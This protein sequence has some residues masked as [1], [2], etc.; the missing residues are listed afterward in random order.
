MSSTQNRTMSQAQELV[1][2][3]LNPFSGPERVKY[4]EDRL[5]GYYTP[6]IRAAFLNTDPVMDR[7]G[8]LG[9]KEHVL[10]A[11]KY[12]RLYNIVNSTMVMEPKL[13]SPDV[14]EE[15]VSQDALHAEV[16]DAL[17]Q[18]WGANTWEI[19]EKQDLIY[20][21]AQADLREELNPAGRQV[22]SQ[23]QSDPELEGQ[24]K[25]AALKE[26]FSTAAKTLVDMPHMTL[27]V[28]MSVQNERTQEVAATI[29]SAI[30]MNQF[31]LAKE[32][33][34]TESKKNKKDRKEQHPL[35]IFRVN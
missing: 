9:K 4:A 10:E 32:K 33:A 22:A 1:G 12:Q 19:A 34:R 5:A 23:L 7:A 11:L 25:G 31:K 30:L 20:A 29:D 16:I 8:E 2:V 21:I 24:Y 26:M 27:S 3:Y 15:T 17:K 35:H 14:R 28:Y 6:T 18:P 13:I